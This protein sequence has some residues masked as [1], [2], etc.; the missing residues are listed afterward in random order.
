MNLNLKDQ[1]VLDPYF[2]YLKVTDNVYRIIIDRKYCNTELIVGTE[3]AAVIDCGL[4]FG[5][6]PAAV[7]KLT[8]KPILLFNTHSHI[9]HIGGN[10]QFDVP[11]HMGSEDIAAATGMDY[12]DFRRNMIVSRI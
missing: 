5:D 8:D 6:L 1:V 2:S 10:A 3:Y 9:D 4:G 12:A 7:R 11:V